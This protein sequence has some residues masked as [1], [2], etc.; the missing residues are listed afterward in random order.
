[1][2][3]RIQFVKGGGLGPSILGTK[4]FA[5]STNAQSRFALVQACRLD[6]FLAITGLWICRNIE[7][8]LEIS[9]EF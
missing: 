4:H 7:F 9:L 6:I 5:F 2:K 3:W 8:F 1:M